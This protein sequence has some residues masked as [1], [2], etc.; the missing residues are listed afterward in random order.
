MSAPVPS[1]RRSFFPVWVALPLAVAAWLRWR[2]LGILDPFVDEGANI[3]TALDP[4]VRAAFEPLAQGRPLLVWLFVPA[5]WFPEHALWA[6]RM[7]TA[8]AGLA[9]MA[10]LGWALHL[11]GG[12]R[13]ALWGLWLWAVLPVAVWHERLALQ[14]PFVTAALAGALALLAAGSRP[15]ATRSQVWW[16]AGAGLLFGTAFLLKI[17][18]LFALPWLGLW[19]FALQRHY[20]RPVLDRR[21]AALAVGVIAPLLLLGTGL[22]HLG[23]GLGRYDALPV[24]GGGFAGLAALHRLQIWLGWYSGYGGWPLLLL[25]GL[26]LVLAGRSIPVR[27]PAW[28]CAGG[29]V[30][31]LLIGGLLYNN[32]HAR[33]SLPDHLPLV[34]FLALA[35]GT[36]TMSGWSRAVL[37]AAALALARWWCVSW[38]IGTAPSRAAVPVAEVTQYVTGPWSGRGTAELRRC[39]ADYA[40]RHQVQCLVLTHPFLRPGCYALMLAALG[41]PRIVVVPLTVYEPEELAVAKRGLVHITSGH[42]AAFFILYEGS[43]YP[44]PPWLDR[45]DTGAKLLHTVDRGDGE[46]FRLYQI[47]P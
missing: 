44:T 40:D 13:A 14:D 10:A 32:A 12:R 15:A 23:A 35:L 8:C 46:A 25:F 45:P 28:C 26:G 33:Y 9:T 24:S 31:S 19:H 37:A 27:S 16:H 11:L 18:A 2:H 42:P 5:G 22:L 34:L 6:A 20:G 29:W 39:L 3:L 47:Q 4:R 1:H 41:D 30:L 36:V 43:L 7:M 21:L 17:S 38:Q